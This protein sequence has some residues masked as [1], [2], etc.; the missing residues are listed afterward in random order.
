MSKEGEDLAAELYDS[1]DE[2]LEIFE[3]TKSQVSENSIV[4]ESLNSLEGD[5]LTLPF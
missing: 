5:E 3:E 2:L 4:D 1:Y